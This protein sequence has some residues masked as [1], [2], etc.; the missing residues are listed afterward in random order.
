MKCVVLLG[1]STTG[2]SSILRGFREQYGDALETLDSDEW[3]ARNHDRHVYNFYRAHR[4]GNSTKRA[5]DL[6][7]EQERQ[8]LRTTT[9]GTKPML[10]A[11]GPFL[12][13]RAPEWDAFRARLSPVCLYLEKEPE[14]VL[15]GLLER[16][17][18][19]R[20]DPQLADDPGF[21]CWDQGSITELQGGRWVLLPW[22]RA[23]ANTRRNMAGVIPRYQQAASG[24]FS[25]RDRSTQAGRDRLNLTIQAALGM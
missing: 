5:N 9:P 6:I 18:R 7:A 22:D 8:F 24:T 16:H 15:C 19:H 13:S 3:L 2:K 21:G 11:A 10:L 25:W 12:P 20:Q 17:Y 14:Y 23:L 1:F 4:E